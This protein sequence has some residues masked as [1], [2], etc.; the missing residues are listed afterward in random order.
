MSEE[1][2]SA[3]GTEVPTKNSKPNSDQ[4]KGND[5]HKV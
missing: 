2:E 5:V 4:N 3:S 1:K